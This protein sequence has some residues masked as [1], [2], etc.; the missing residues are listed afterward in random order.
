MLEAAGEDVEEVHNMGVPQIGAALLMVAQGQVLVM[1]S[2][3][4]KFLS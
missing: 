3:V 2:M 4:E 1:I